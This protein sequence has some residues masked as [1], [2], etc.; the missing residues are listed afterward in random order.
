MDMIEWN[1]CSDERN[2]FSLEILYNIKWIFSNAANGPERL[3]WMSQF[4]NDLLYILFRNY[5]AGG[6][7]PTDHK[8]LIHPPN[9]GEG[10][11][12]IYLLGSWGCDPN[13]PSPS[14]ALE[15]PSSSA[16]K[17]CIIFRWFIG[18]KD[19]NYFRKHTCLS[20]SGSYWNKFW[21]FESVS[22]IIYKYWSRKLYFF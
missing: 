15:A 13:S 9:I 17:S 8:P 7:F 12:R 4:E 14:S 20:S 1:S 6:G 3:S 2:I 10:H 5:L 22:T 21:A 11:P 18:K 19:T 16:T